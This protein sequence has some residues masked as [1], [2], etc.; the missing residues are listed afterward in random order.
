LAHRQIESGAS[1]LMPWITRA[2]WVTLSKPR[3]SSSPTTGVTC[4]CGGRFTRSQRIGFEGR[5]A[6]P[7][8]G[9]DT[10][11]GRQRL[12]AERDALTAAI[13]RLLALAEAGAGDVAELAAKLKART[14]E[15]ETLNRRIA[16]LPA[17]T[18]GADLRAVL[19]KRVAN[20][21]TRLLSEFRDEARF[22]LDQLL[23]F[24]CDLIADPS[25]QGVV[26]WCGSVKDD[27][28]RPGRILRRPARQAGTRDVDLI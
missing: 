9:G 12:A 11:N 27:G 18:S 16:L 1:S 25:R 24:A 28:G 14:A 22:V 5:Q 23:H 19:E 7:K 21:K 8:N 26:V 2:N 17:P 10:D 4:V 20:W 3:S 6:S 15:R 13:S